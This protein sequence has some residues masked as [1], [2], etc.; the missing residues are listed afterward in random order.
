VA[1][2]AAGSAATAAAEAVAKAAGANRAGKATS[3][4]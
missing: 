4:F 1:D 2:V 3:N